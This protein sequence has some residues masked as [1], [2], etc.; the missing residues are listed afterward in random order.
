MLQTK[1]L[2]GLAV[3]ES[4]REWV[5]RSMADRRTK[6]AGAKVGFFEK[7]LLDGNP[8]V[9]VAAAIA[10]GRLGD[11]SAAE[12]LFTL[13]DPPEGTYQPEAEAA[14]VAPPAFMSKKL[15]PHQPAAKINVDVKGWKELHLVVT[16]G[17]DG[18]DHDHAGWFDPTLVM[19]DGSEKK[20]TDLKW[21]SAKGGWGKTLVGKDCV[22]KPLTRADEK[23]SSF[24][25]GT[26]SPSHIVYDLPSGA[27]K[28]KGF[29]GATPGAH[30]GRGHMEY[31][32]DS[33]P[34]V[35]AQKA[36]GPHATPNAT[37]VLPHV[38]ITAIRAVGA[39]DTALSTLDGPNRQAALWAL[40]TIARTGC[41]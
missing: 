40:K 31:V 25:I 15:K 35:F 33:K 7:G 18:N 30:D 3:D 28:F 34:P 29:G 11:A 2:A 6:L 4:I 9:Q 5:V 27:V 41:C 1:K 23:K 32:V 19:A 21:K 16:E 26:H 13:A 24:G 8:R 36:E 38:S 10:L 37:I 22:S 39:N 12:A 14:T 20:L 17:G